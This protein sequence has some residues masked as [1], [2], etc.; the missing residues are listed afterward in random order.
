[1]NEEKRHRTAWKNQEDL[2]LVETLTEFVAK[3]ISIH[4]AFP[5]VVERLNG[6]TQAA[7]YSR[8]NN[9][10][11]PI[12]GEAIEQA[13]SKQK[14][15]A[16]RIVESML[17]KQANLEV[18]HGEQKNM[19]IYVPGA[20]DIRGP[21]TPTSTP[22]SSFNDVIEFLKQTDLKV[23]EMQKENQEMSEMLEE[24]WA[25]TE[26]LKVKLVDYDKLKAHCDEL[27]E[28]YNKLQGLKAKLQEVSK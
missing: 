24:A 20:P 5:T 17:D 8:W 15:N 4:E 2:V 28:K 11:E 1:M 9:Y 21:I 19:E 14:E 18:I 13:V 25:E 23:L 16:Q 26:E 3:G 7:C 6:R 12:Y 10:L 27:V 22:F